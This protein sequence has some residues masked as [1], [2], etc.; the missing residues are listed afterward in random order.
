MG[1]ELLHADLLIREHKYKSLPNHIHLL[2]RQTIHF[3]Y[4][5]ALNLFETHGLKPY[6]V[7]VEFDATTVSAQYYGEKHITDT[8]FFGMFGAQ[9]TAIDHS[10]YE[11][12]ELIIDLNKELDQKHMGIA[13]FIY[14]GSV[15]DNVFNP[16]TY[17][18]NVANILNTGGR[19]LDVN[20]LTFNTHPYSVQSPAWFFDFYALNGF[21]DFKL[22]CREYA[23]HSNMYSMEISNH[24]TVLHSLNA[25]SNNKFELVYIAEK[26]EPVKKTL[27]PSQDQYRS[28]EEWDTI[29]KQLALMKTSSRNYENF[30]LPNS[31]QVQIMPPLNIDLYSYRGIFSPFNSEPF[32][33]DV[34]AK[35]VH[36]AVSGKG[37]K[38]VSATY[39]ANVFSTEPF[40]RGTLPLCFDNVKQ[41]IAALCDGFEQCERIIDVNQLGDPAP[42]QAKDLSIYYTYLED[43][44]KRLHHSYIGAEA[45]GKPLNIPKYTPITSTTAGIKILSATYG[46]NVEADSVTEPG[47]LALCFDNIKDALAAHCDGKASCDMPVD[48]TMFGDPAPGHA[49]ALSVYYIYSDD[50]KGKLHHAYIDPEASGQRLHIPSFI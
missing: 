35:S 30:A 34:Y 4:D 9:V 16:A 29:R 46:L 11:G 45:H 28:D 19:I 13:D 25:Y 27:F 37:I 6:D 8:T 5:D 42:G 17:I 43:P 38:I 39:G 10:D 40:K 3:S 2:G 44:H 20:V 26:G 24:D 50:P 23:S 18:K 14:G 7:D 47:T 41:T 12:A 32:D 33:C 15:C 22:Y 21:K 1:I 31:E 49:K 48:V 36:P